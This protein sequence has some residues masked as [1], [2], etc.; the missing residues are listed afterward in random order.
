ML[1]GQVDNCI[2]GF[3]LGTD[4]SKISVVITENKDGSGYS[5]AMGSLVKSGTSTA[6]TVTSDSKD[7]Y[8][9]TVV[10]GIRSI[11]NFNSNSHEYNRESNSYDSKTALWTDDRY[12]RIWQNKSSD[13]FPESTNP[14]YPSMG[15]GNTGELYASFSNYSTPKPRRSN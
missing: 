1:R 8:L 13:Y 5:F 11:N 7:G 4:I 3:N 14:V 6:F 10:N 2:E 15:V 12:V 9:S